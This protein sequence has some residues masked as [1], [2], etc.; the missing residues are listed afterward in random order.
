GNGPD[1][2]ADQD[3]GGVRVPQDEAVGPA[4]DPDLLLDVLRLLDDLPDQHAGGLPAAVRLVGVRGDR[5]LAA[6]QRPVPRPAGAAALPAHRQA[7]SLDVARRDRWGRR[8]SVR[9]P[10]PSPPRGYSP[11]AAVAAS[12]L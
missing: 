8:W 3:G 5:L 4:V 2:H 9:S 12:H 11:A 7:G 6:G 1:G 10:A